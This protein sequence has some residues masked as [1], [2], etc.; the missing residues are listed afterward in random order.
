MKTYMIW[1]PGRVIWTGDDS[2]EALDEFTT[3]LKDASEQQI[4]TVKL[5]MYEQTEATGKQ[6]E[7]SITGK[8]ALEMIE[9]NG[10]S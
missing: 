2:K 8:E 7:F 9:S 3:Y 10:N 4:N 1:I 6:P 5:T